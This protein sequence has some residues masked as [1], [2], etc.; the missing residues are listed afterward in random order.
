MQQINTYHCSSAMLEVSLRISE[1][2]FS[3]FSILYGD[4]NFPI[5]FW[6]FFEDSEFLSV[7]FIWIVFLEF[8]IGI[9]I[10]KKNHF[11]FGVPRGNQK[12]YAELLMGIR[13]SESFLD[14]FMG[15][16]ISEGFLDFFMGIR[17]SASFLDFFM[18]MRISVFW[19]SFMGIRISQSFLDFFMGISISECFLGFFM[20]IRNSECFFRLLYWN[21]NSW[22]FFGLLLGG[23]E[24]L[25]VFLPNF[26]GNLIRNSELSLESFSVIRD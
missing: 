16:R 6:S 3:F 8:L 14:F 2:F 4:Q 21:Q 18:G 5:P 24:F 19:T 17:I 11:S 12:F 13:I 9:R 20:G 7:F 1:W 26:Y 25:N 22:V 15:I 10:A 23:S